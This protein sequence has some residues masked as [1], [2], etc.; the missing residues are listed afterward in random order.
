MSVF[1]F[2]VDPQPPLRLIDARSLQAR[3]EDPIQPAEPIN[4]RDVLDLPNTDQGPPAALFRPPIHDGV[5]VAV[6]DD[7]MGQTAARIAWTFLHF[8]ANNVTIIDPQ[9]T[10]NAARTPTSAGPVR[11]DGAWV[12]AHIGKADT[13]FLDVRGDTERAGGTLP[14]AVAWNWTR[15]L[16]DAGGF[17]ATDDVKQDLLEAG[18]RQDATVVTYCQS[19]LRAAHTFWLLRA[20]GWP[21]VRLYEGS[22]ADWTERQA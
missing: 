11:A 16:N 4:L 21:D 8:G 20:L 1:P 5:T 13:L 7:A 19:G 3:N 14:E 18:V 2:S 6:L 22:W 15:G 17:N 10:H 12:E 9:G